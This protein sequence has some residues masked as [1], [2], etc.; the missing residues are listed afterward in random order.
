MTRWLRPVMITIALA[1]SLL[2]LAQ[3]GGSSLRPVSRFMLILSATTASLLLGLRLVRGLTL[4][5][6]RVSRR[7]FVLLV[8]ATAI[9]ALLVAG[10]SAVSA[11]LGSASDRALVAGRDYVGAARALRDE[12]AVAIATSAQAEARLRDVA[13]IH[14]RRGEELTVWLRRDAWRR[15]T[16]RAAAAE[17]ALEAWPAAPS[18]GAALVRVDST[19]YVAA[20]ARGADSS[21]VAVAWVSTQGSLA[22]EISRRAGA[23]IVF[24][25]GTS[26]DSAG[27][28]RPWSRAGRELVHVLDDTRLSPFQ[29]FAEIEGWSWIGGRWAPANQMLAARVEFLPSLGGLVRNAMVTPVALVPV[30]FLSLF[31]LLGVRILFVTGATLRAIGR[32]ITSA[33]GA[34]REG[35]SALQ[36]GRLDHRIPISGDDELWDVAAAFNQAAEGLERGRA[37]E[38]ERERSEN[39]LALARRIQARL[40]PDSPPD[41]PGLE[42]AGLSRAAQAVGGDYYDHVALGNGRVALVIADV[43][44][45]GVPAALLMSGFRASL[46]SQLDTHSDPALAI[47]GVNRFLHRSVESGRFVTAF[48]AIVDGKDGKIVYCNAGHNAPLLV[49]PDGV[50]V[51]LDQGGLLLGMLEDA[52]YDRGEAV[53]EAGATLA[54]YT[55]GV[56]EAR[57]RDGAMWGEERLAE[58][59]RRTAAEP[60]A[61]AAED[62]ADAVRAFEGDQGPSDDLTLLLAR[63]ARA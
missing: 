3:G 13:A 40:L 24:A 55:D 44:G 63:R 29:G 10:F 43:S 46:L 45:K 39:E 1:S 35:V 12:L 34:L 22:R 37:L 53:L 20:R 36:A 6:R 62:L 47:A 38:L 59:L 52:S 32:S 28:S 23:R 2:L 11:W 57:S 21:L 5:S 30:V 58:H 7:L 16:G 17:A 14:A 60:C 56:V 15:L 51:P 42:I 25:G 61:R 4:R 54:L 9:P 26:V 48:L 8:F 49:A 33:V 31:I 19:T 27:S 50:V 18:A 41:V